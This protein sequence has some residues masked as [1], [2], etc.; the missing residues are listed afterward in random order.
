MFKTKPTI[1]PAAMVSPSFSTT[2]IAVT[3]VK[4]VTASAF[5]Q[6][7]AWVAVYGSEDKSL[8]VL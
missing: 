1:S 8:A 6:P 3:F 2:L 5:I 4:S 7:S